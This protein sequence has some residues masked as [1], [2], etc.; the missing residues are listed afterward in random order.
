M[1]RPG[2]RRFPVIARL[3][4]HESATKLDK[5]ENAMLDAILYSASLTAS[6]LCLR[7][8]YDILDI[9][10]REFKPRPRINPR[11]LSFLLRA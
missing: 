5:R 9:A 8:L 4:A 11:R 6:L 3:V 10:A 1:A 2:Y 7:Y